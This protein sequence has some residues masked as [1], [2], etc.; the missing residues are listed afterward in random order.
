MNLEKFSQCP[1]LRWQPPPLYFMHI[2][3]TGGTSLEVHLTQSYGKQNFQV[4]MLRRLNLFDPAE[5]HAYRC[6]R[7]HCGPGL[8]PFLPPQVQVITCLREPVERFISHLYMTQ[9]QL[10]SQLARLPTT[11]LEDLR[12][13]TQASLRD[14]LDH[15]ASAFFDNFQTRHLG[16]PLQLEPW[17]KHGELGRLKQRVPLLGLPAPLTDA[18]DMAQVFARACQQLEQIAVVGI[19]EHFAESMA[20]VCALLGVPTPAQLPTC[21]RNPAKPEI[22]SHYYG[23]QLTPDLREAIQARTHYDQALYAYACDLFAQQWARQRAQPKRIYSIAPR[24]RAT[25]E[26]P[27]SLVTGTLRQVAP[28]LILNRRRQR[29]IQR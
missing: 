11:T 24:L 7:S 5:L 9:R 29:P 10:T 3:K 17:F 23:K 2:P 26:A 13:L 8:L 16:A 12:P 15:P 22:Q 20:L 4:V 28:Q 25:V 19:T 1:T 27:L 18:S 6:W 14:W 21:N